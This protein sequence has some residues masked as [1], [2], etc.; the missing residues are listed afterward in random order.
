MKGMKEKIMGSG[1]LGAGNIGSG[2]AMGT[3][4]MG[5]KDARSRGM[6]KAKK[7]GKTISKSPRLSEKPMGS[8]TAKAVLRQFIGTRKQT[9]ASKLAGVGKLSTGKGAKSLKFGGTP[10]R[11]YSGR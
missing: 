7:G 9:A 6:A 3:N 4:G 8:G 11:H 1:T 2:L 10:V 5:A